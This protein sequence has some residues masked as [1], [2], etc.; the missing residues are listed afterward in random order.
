MLTGLKDTDREVLKYVE[1][2]ELFTVCCVNKRMWY[3]VCDDRFIRRRLLNINSE[4]EKYK[5]EDE[6]WKQFFARATYYI[7]I[8]ESYEF[9]YTSGDFE[10]Q[11]K[12]VKDTPILELLFVA[13]KE[14]ELEIMKY[15]IHNGESKDNALR[16]S[17]ENGHLHLV[18]YLIEVEKADISYNEHE[19]LRWASVFGHYEVVKYL[20]ENGAD[21]HASHDAALKWGAF[22]GHLNVVKLLAES[23]ANIHASNDFALLT[24]QDRQ[25]FEIVK[26]LNEL[27]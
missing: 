16:L 4:I 22:H 7:S 6:T 14:G 13:C 10:K 12:I 17:A 1:D 2:N 23:S 18:K 19:S 15:A 20:L 5:K 25:H 3:E 21:V 27:P 11:C 9:K 8:L 24:A 26:Y